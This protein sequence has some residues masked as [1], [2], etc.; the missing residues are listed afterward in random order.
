MTAAGKVTSG[1]T[2]LTCDPNPYRKEGV[3]ISWAAVC[4]F[5]LLSP[6]SQSHPGLSSLLSCSQQSGWLSQAGKEADLPDTMLRLYF[7]TD[8]PVSTGD[9]HREADAQ[10]SPC[11]GSGQMIYL[12]PFKALLCEWKVWLGQTTCDMNFVEGVCFRNL[13][14]I[15]KALLLLHFRID[16]LAVNIL[17]SKVS[18]QKR[19]PACASLQKIKQSFKWN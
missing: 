10:P 6:F 18:P 13:D 4:T 2:P 8:Q 12:I 11:T 16:L 1:W 17:P 9:R 14:L 5:Y 19:K 7:S 15:F 3:F